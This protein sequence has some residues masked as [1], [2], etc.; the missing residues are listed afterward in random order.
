M[1]LHP[2]LAELIIDVSAIRDNV[3]TLV[4]IA[5]PAQVMAII[6]ADGYNHGAQDVAQA[7]IDGGA[8]QLGVATI[9]EAMNLRNY[10]FTCPIHAWMWCPGENLTAPMAA[11]ITIGVPSIAHAKAVVHAATERHA[12]TGRKARV[13]LM[14]DTG[15]SRSGVSPSELTG[16]IELLAEHR[17]VVDVTGMSSHLASADM[18]SGREI[19]DLQNTRFSR[20]IQQARCAGL[21][22]DTNHLANTPATLSRPDLRHQMVRPGVSIYGVDPLETSSGVQLRSAMTFRAR[23]ITTRTVP[24]GE[25]VS[26]GHQWRAQRDT[27]TA[28]VAAGYA[29]GVP[30]SASGRFEV[31][32]NGQRYKQIGRVCMDQFV[33]ELP[34][35]ANVEPGDWAVIFGHGGP[36]VDELAAATGTIAYENLTLPRGPRV[37][38]RHVHHPDQ[39]A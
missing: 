21:S 33:I 11:D 6:K 27:R 30:R 15:M 28:V 16:T 1:L 34:D 26:Y 22:V 36:H 31:A 5:S 19:T 3:S 10:G 38:R 37:T 7:A 32:I 13:C 35:D 4:D 29:D 39:I 17:D 20:A 8:H 18:D 23:V 14:V 2:T 9:A 12:A 24:A 25:G